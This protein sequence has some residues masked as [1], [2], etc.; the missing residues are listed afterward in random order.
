M[1]PAY[2]RARER[3][4][5]W[6]LRE[7][8]HGGSSAVNALLLFF[9]LFPIAD[10]LDS[11]VPFP[12]AFRVAASRI[13]IRITFVCVLPS[14]ATRC[15]SGHPP[16]CQL[17]GCP[18]LPT[19]IPCHRRHGSGLLLLR[20]IR[21]ARGSILAVTRLASEPSCIKSRP[22]TARPIVQKFRVETP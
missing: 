20:R 3:G 11:P 16:N 14:L 13:R 22:Y 5:W 6:H 18:L 9:F 17:G 8:A 15:S 10:P 19:G 7:Y 2:H 4:G 12:L 21:D 1:V